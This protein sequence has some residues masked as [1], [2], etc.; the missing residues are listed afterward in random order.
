MVVYRIY[1]SQITDTPC[2]KSHLYGLVENYAY[3]IYYYA[4]NLAHLCAAIKTKQ[5][6]QMEYLLHTD[7]AHGNLTYTMWS[8]T[9][10]HT[11]FM[12]KIGKKNRYFAV[13]DKWR[14]STIRNSK[15]C[16]LPKNY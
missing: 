13:M 2:G 12:H 11:G 7:E 5:N 8:H 9:H 16:S 14:Q 15:K 4:A 1:V 6:K 10:T 3:V